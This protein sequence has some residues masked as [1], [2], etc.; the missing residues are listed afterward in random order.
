[1][2]HLSFAMLAP[3]LVTACAPASRW[4]PLV[5]THAGTPTGYSAA[6]GVGRVLRQQPDP[7][8]ARSR[9]DLDAFALVEPGSRGGRLSAGLGTDREHAVTKQLVNVRLSALRRWSGR[10][11]GNYAGVELQA[12]TIEEG[13][14]LGFRVGLFAPVIRRHGDRPLAFAIDFPAGW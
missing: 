6:A 10:S 3:L 14:P 9:S 12:E 2:R 8:S 1:M 4:R 5:G 11:I 7:R 13:I